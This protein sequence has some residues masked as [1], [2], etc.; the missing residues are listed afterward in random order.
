MYD[1]I[2]QGIRLKAGESLVAM[3]VLPPELVQQVSAV[4]AAAKEEQDGAAA[5]GS[6]AAAEA[7]AAAAV[8]SSS[9]EEQQGPWLLLVT[10]L[11]TS[12]RVLL[13]DVPCKMSRG[14]QGVIGIKLNAGTVS[15]LGGLWEWLLA[16]L[17]G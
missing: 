10:R 14:V 9:A 13:S 12:K 4:Q 17:R 11:G 6:A 15:S 8:S 5:A 16:G 2:V 1:I 3:A 7:A